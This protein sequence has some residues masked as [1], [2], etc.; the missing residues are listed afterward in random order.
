MESNWIKISLFLSVCTL[1]L[2]AP[3]LSLTLLG[4][5][6]MIELIVQAM[7]FGILALSLNLLLGYTGLPSLGHTA[8]LGIAA[9]AVAI[10]LT[11]LHLSPLQASLAGVLAAT[12]CGAIFGLL[13]LRARGVYFLMITLALAMLV[14]G[15]AY[16]WVSVTQ[17]DNGIS[18]ILRPEIGSWSLRNM[19]SY[20]YFVFIVF[21]LS[22]YTIYRIV[23]SPFG[24]SLIGIKES[25]SRMRTLGY[26]VWLHKYVCF[27]IASF[28]GGVSGV[29]FIFYNGF[30]S[31]PTLEVTSNMETLL[32]VA[33][34]GPGT[35]VGPFIGAFVIV[36]LKNFV[37]VYTG[38][39]LMILGL[40]YIV[41]I[42]YAPKGL[43][44]LAGL[45]RKVTQAKPQK[46]N[47]GEVTS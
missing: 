22:F 43:L 42:L 9:Y 41:T 46:K 32:M 38:R 18:G 15:L 40:I 39:W 28:F 4:S 11:K 3:W 30:I 47:Q 7:I 17:G 13:A 26:N 35:I 2:I 33:L 12:F 23:H 29:L 31:P 5:S 36:L 24:R 20:Y 34:G 14:W 21:S 19:T 37:S 6:Y 45:W 16:R 44:E 8:Y 10:C 25:E 27:V 1:F